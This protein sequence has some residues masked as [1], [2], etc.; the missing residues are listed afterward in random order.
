M[1]VRLGSYQTTAFQ[2]KVLYM[3]AHLH[4]Q[5]GFAACAQVIANRMGKPKHKMAVTTALH[6]VRKATPIEIDNDCLGFRSDFV[7][8]CAAA[9][10]WDSRDWVGLDALYMALGYTRDGGRWRI[11]SCPLP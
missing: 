3:L 8:Q 10:R 1:T 2:H 9:D 6:A 5:R 4:G 11:D 7:H